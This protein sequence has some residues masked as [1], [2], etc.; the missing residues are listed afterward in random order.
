MLPPWHHHLSFLLRKFLLMLWL[1]AST[2]CLVTQRASVPLLSRSHSWR[3]WNG[4]GSPEEPLMSSRYQ[5]QS[6]PERVIFMNS[7]RYAS[8]SIVCFQI[9]LTP[10]GWYHQFYDIAGNHRWST[11]PLCISSIPPSAALVPYPLPYGFALSPETRFDWN[12]CRQDFIQAS[13]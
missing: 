2:R 9:K 13:L 4:R 11:I 7:L 12:P 10:L 1:S 8:F 5:V 3:S 6:L